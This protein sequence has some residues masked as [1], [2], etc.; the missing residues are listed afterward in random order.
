MRRIILLILA[1]LVGG[2][3]YLAAR[4]WLFPPPDSVANQDVRPLTSAEQARF[5]P[6]VCAGASAGSDGYAH[7]CAS[8]PGYPSDD[9]GGAGLGLGITLTSITEGQLTGT[10]RL[11]AYVSYLGSFE[12]HVTN[13]G[14]G[15][16]FSA[17]GQGAWTLDKWFPGANLDGCLSL[18]PQ[19][20]A[21][22]LCLEGYTGQGETDTSLMVMQVASA[23]K[24]VLAAADLR[25]TLTPDGNCGQLTAPTQAV[26]LGLTGLR[27]T[28][29]G[30]S[31]QASY[32]PAGTAA[33]A[34]AAH[35]FAA[36]PTQ[37]ATLTLVPAGDGFTI[38]PTLD[39][40]PPEA[41]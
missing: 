34:C 33:K 41:P 3:G 37:T 29:S 28:A 1:V 36:A 39:F 11:E 38:S 26:L 31:V 12:P 15:I 13:F 21:R 8:L 19:G 23:A 40:A 32:V 6:L 5:L 27:R 2:G 9:Y 20:R 22:F 10:G 25:A 18:S 7:N 35:D 30:V 16:L 4:A 14:G 17:N 24:T